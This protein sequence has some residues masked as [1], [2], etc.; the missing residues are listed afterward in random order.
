MELKEIKEEESHMAFEEIKE[1]L[2][3]VE[4]GPIVSDDDLEE[5]EEIEID[6]CI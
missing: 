2:G 6:Q 4:E 1:R 3:I 5:V